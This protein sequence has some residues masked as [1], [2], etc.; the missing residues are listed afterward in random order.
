MERINM[1][2][3]IRIKNETKQQIIYLAR[4]LGKTQCQL[5]SEIFE[6]FSELVVDFE[7]PSNVRVTIKKHSE[8][9]AGRVIFELHGSRKVISG[10]SNVGEEKRDMEKALNAKRSEEN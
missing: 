1:T 2:T 7:E 6:A 10:V 9:L 3:H 5:I 8:F 4:L